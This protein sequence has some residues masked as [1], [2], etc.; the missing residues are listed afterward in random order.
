[1]GSLHIKIAERLHPF[2]HNSGTFCPIPFTTWEVQV[3]PT[4]LYFRNLKTFEDFELRLSIQGGVKDF[5]VELDLENGLIRVFGTSKEGYIEYLIDRDA[6]HFKKLPLSGILCGE[7]T[8]HKGAIFDLPLEAESIVDPQE[9]L[10]LGMH[11]S[12]D[13]DL[14]KRRADLTEIFPQWLRLAALIPKETIPSLPNEG[15][16]SLLNDCKQAIEKG[17]KNRIVPIFTLLFQAAFQGILSPRLNDELYLGLAPETDA[18]Y[19]PL[20]ILST[21][22]ELIRSL[23]FKKENNTFSFLPS[24]PPEFH[25][26]RFMIGDEIAIEWS[27]KLIK[28]IIL[29]SNH[30]GEVHLKF[31]SSIQSFRLRHTLKERGKKIFKDQPISLKSGQLIYLDRFEK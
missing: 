30:T 15:T 19:S 3:F 1:M 18:T 28:K 31:Q 24:L 7:T 25:S 2:S 29:R 9:R 10:S 12:Q 17:E 26:G 20:A 6:L 23:F 14:V 16:L 8:V 22:A 21:G 5:T 27:K 11:R 13:W 4:C